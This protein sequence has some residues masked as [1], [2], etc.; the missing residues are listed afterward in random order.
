MV[1]EHVKPYFVEKLQPVDSPQAVLWIALLFIATCLLTSG[2]VEV[3]RKAHLAPFVATSSPKFWAWFPVVL[4]LGARI[5]WPS[6]G[7]FA[8][9]ALLPF[10]LSGLALSVLSL[11]HRLPARGLV[12]LMGT[13]V[14]GRWLY[15]GSLFRLAA[16]SEVLPGFEGSTLIALLVLVVCFHWAT[17]KPKRLTA[18]PLFGKTNDLVEAYDSQIKAA[19]IE[20]CAVLTF[21]TVMSF[22]GR[23]PIGGELLW[24]LGI[25]TFNAAFLRSLVEGPKTLP[26]TGERTFASVCRVL[27]PLLVLVVLPI[28]FTFGSQIP[29]ERPLILLFLALGL[30]L[31]RPWGT[32][33]SRS[34]G[35]G[36][37]SLKKKSAHARRFPWVAVVAAIISLGFVVA[38][39]NEFHASDCQATMSPSLT[40]RLLSQELDWKFRADFSTEKTVLLACYQGASISGS[41]ASDDLLRARA[42][43]ERASSDYEVVCL[44]AYPGIWEILAQVS[45]CALVLPCLTIAAVF[46][47]KFSPPGV[48]V[49]RWTFS[50]FAGVFLAWGMA[51]VWHWVWL[52]SSLHL[53]VSALLAALSMLDPERLLRQIGIL[54]SPEEPS[55]LT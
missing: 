41:P 53:A 18:Q 43:I 47:G 48:Q 42:I 31:G 10:V 23:S 32:Q 34:H 25:L 7:F 45:L 36:V 27:C 4:F 38:A 21:S 12:T 52:D 24:Y 13:L 16:N 20:F 50:L 22:E 5:A 6:S 51:G 28:S 55:T 39:V 29:R 17:R 40:K 49:W 9:I 37:S 44:Q 2:L 30:M 11:N 33:M 35:D 46:L 1:R 8:D 54:R 14:V 26:T 15:L 19:M 3:S